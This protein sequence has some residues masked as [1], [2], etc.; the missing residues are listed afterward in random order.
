M[1]RDTISRVTDQVL[2]D[3]RSWRSRP[4]D[5]VYPIV[6][7]DAMTVK[8]RED[9]SVQNRCCYLAVGVTLEG[10][11]DCLGIWWREVEGAKFWL[12]VLNDLHQRGV[13]S[14]PCPKLCARR[15]TPRIRS[16]DAPPGPQSDQDPRPLPRRAGRH[17]AD[18]AGDPASRNQM[19]LGT[20]LD[21]RPT[22]AQDPL[23]RPNP[24]LT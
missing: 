4:L 17:Q 13:R 2:E 22:S 24:R 21:K 8:V 16:G 20:R 15:S 19:A 11:R 7:F 6:Y 23:R 9:R 18:L 14:C 3:I 12:A 10:E 5:E 1:G